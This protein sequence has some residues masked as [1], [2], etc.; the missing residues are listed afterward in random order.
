[1]KRDSL[2]EVVRTGLAIGLALLIGFI[3]TVLVSKSPLEAF[4]YF[5]T[6]PFTSTR[7]LGAFIEAAVPL[8]FTGLAVSLVFSAG[9]FN[10]G[11][12]G[13]FFIGAVAATFAGIRLDLPPFIHA[14]VALIFGAVAGS[15]AGF[16]P[17]YLKSRWNASELVS[18]LMLNYV[19]LKL[20]MYVITYHLRDINVGALVSLPLKETSWLPQFLPPTRLHAGIVVLVLCVIFCHWFLFRTGW[21]YEIR[22]TGLNLNFARYSG[23]P[24]T[25]VILYSQVLSGAVA[26]LGGAVEMLGIYRRFQWLASPGYGFDGVIIAILARNNPLLVPVGAIFL[27]YL[28]VGADVMAMYSDVTSE[29]VSVIQAVI[30]L[31]VTAQAFLSGYRHRLVLREVKRHE[32]AS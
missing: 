13:Q 27:A 30:I 20:G 25:S 19:F 15:V 31:L 16:V 6:G 7:R 32:S 5:L 17:G 9:Q 18:S 28:R 26:G 14:L 1:M 24:V 4:K 11:A 2:F 3:V 21:G 22:M 29:M 10:I 23:I 8:T 12:E